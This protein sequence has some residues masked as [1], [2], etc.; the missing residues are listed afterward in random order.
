ME[1]KMSTP[2]VG[3]NVLNEMDTVVEEINGIKADVVFGKTSKDCAGLGICKVSV[4]NS[5]HHS[6][7]D[8]HKA[9]AILKKDVYGQLRFYFLTSTIC[10]DCQKKYFP[11]EEFLV[12]ESFVLPKSL[13]RAMDLPCRVIAAGRYPA[14]KMKDYLLVVFNGISG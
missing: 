9:Q 10:S 8:C 1:G 14:V 4:T 11:R 7:Y 6:D 13:A 3:L 12:G 2:S 5:V